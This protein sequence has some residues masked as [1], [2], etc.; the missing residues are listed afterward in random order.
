MLFRSVNFY[1]KEAGN[2]Y[3]SPLVVEGR[4]NSS[5]KT[6]SDSVIKPAVDGKITNLYADMSKVSGMSIESL[7][8][9]AS[10]QVL[11]EKDM[12]AGGRYIDLFL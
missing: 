1:S 2:V 3:S 8:R 4:Y 6:S 5:L 12:R 11:L 7:R 10:L 9:A